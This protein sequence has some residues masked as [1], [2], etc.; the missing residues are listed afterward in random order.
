MVTTTLCAATIT[1]DQP[2]QEQ[3]IR[4]V[5]NADA[6]AE[7]YTENAVIGDLNC[8][9][10]PNGKYGYFR[11]DDNQIYKTDKNLIVK[12]TYFDAGSGHFYFHYNALGSKYQ[13]ITVKKTN[14]NTW[15]TL[16]AAITDAAFDNA[17]NNSADFRFSGDTYIRKVEI[18]VGQLIPASEPV[19]TTGGSSYSEFKG[20]SVA[21]YQAWFAANSTNSNWVH[22]PKGG[23]QRPRVGNSSFELYPDMRDYSQEQKIMTDFADFGN[24]EPAT[25]FNSADVVD[26]H[27]DW[28]KEAGIDGV[29]LQ[30]FI[31]DSPYPII[32]S[33]M[34]IPV[35]VKKAAEARQKIFYVCYDMSSGKDENAWVESIKFDW[36]FNIE[37]SYELTSSPA[38]ATVNNKPVVQIWG[39][40]FTSRVGNAAKTIE[41]IQFLQGRGC[42]VIGGVPTGWRSE[43]RDSK[44]N[45]LQAYKTYDMVS[46]WTP[47]RYGN[48]SAV[49]AHADNYWKPDNTYCKANNMDY[50]PVLFP[51]FAWATWNVGKPNATP[52]DNGKFLWRQAYNIKKAGISEMYFAM[53][54]EY[55]EGT[56]IMKGATDWSMIPTDQYFLTHSADGMW[57]SSDFYLRLAGAAT[58]ML[59]NSD[60]A[61]ADISI[62]YSEGP[63]YYRNSF[64]KRQ[65]QY[66]EKENGPILSG[67]YNLDPC[68]FNAS[69][70]GNVNVSSATCFIA[71]EGNN[72]KSGKYLVKFKGEPISASAATYSYKI[73]DVKIPVVENLQ[74]SF[75]KKTLN[76]L[77][78]YANVDLE[79]ASGKKLSAL[80]TYINNHGKTMH[81]SVGQG[82]VNGDWENTVCKIGE[83]VLLGDVI[84]KIIIT[85]DRPA[86]E[87]TF[88]AY[89]D[90]LLIASDLPA[91]TP[92]TSVQN[93]VTGTKIQ[94]VNSTLHLDGFAPDS[95][96]QVFNLGGQVTYSGALTSNI[97][98]LSLP[99]GIYLVTVTN[100]QDA[101]CQK[102]KF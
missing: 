39:P 29:A 90:D 77:G 10:I 57:L 24:G 46:P 13:S 1:F 71:E 69:N 92:E 98:R 21:G 30:R 32:S 78:Q 81:A 48:I 16:T 31:G 94:V 22:W 83:G 85:Y 20:K 54:D 44:P 79:F 35:K 64:E 73:A 96:V 58:S 37:Q 93:Y 52:R 43:N 61:Q 7:A 11:A 63:V 23:G 56:A 5:A 82:T 49:D 3:G 100:K 86:S 76:H 55:D 33:E 9:F 62:N 14:S 26:V 19:P 72:S 70:A 97:I 28:M 67:V 40:G 38:Y 18:T 12:L 60:P 25:L 80:S 102:I 2:I 53:F 65:Q 36:V 50:M 51:G 15:I 89:F 6:N 4:F 59:K 75:Y 47:G 99:K 66:Q 88:E 45:F 8:R 42:Y 101:Y 87:G 74:L 17:Q 41:L 95:K 34:A 91:Y 84:T 27:F 68:F